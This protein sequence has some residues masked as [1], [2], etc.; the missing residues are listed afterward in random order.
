M[1]WRA[2][3]KAWQRLT[4]REGEKGALTAEYHH[5]SGWVWHLNGIYAM[6]F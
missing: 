2:A 6:A 4:L 1:G 5:A 3:C